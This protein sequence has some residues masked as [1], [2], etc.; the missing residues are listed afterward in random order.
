MPIIVNG[1]T[2]EKVICNDVTVDTVN[3]NGTIVYE[4]T[5]LLS[6]Y[7]GTIHS[8]STKTFWTNNTD[9]IVTVFYTLSCTGG[10]FSSSYFK[11]GINENFTVTVSN[12]EVKSGS[13][14]V[15][16]G[17]TVDVN[18]YYAEGDLTLWCYI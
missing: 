6:I 10:D 8:F 9:S 14:V 7:S 13:L 4:S 18:E 3:V 11:I 17:A 15:P 1:V 5:Q 12:G 2:I 16:P